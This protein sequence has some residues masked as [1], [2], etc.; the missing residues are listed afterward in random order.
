MLKCYRKHPERYQ[1]IKAGTHC[2]R[3]VCGRA[4]ARIEAMA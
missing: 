1:V 2:Y 3:I 4:V